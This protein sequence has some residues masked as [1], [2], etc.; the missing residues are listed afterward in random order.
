MTHVLQVVYG[1]P[2]LETLVLLGYSQWIGLG[3]CISSHVE[4]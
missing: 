3:V 4:L 2:S 1:L